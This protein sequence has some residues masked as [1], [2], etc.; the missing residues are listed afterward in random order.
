MKKTAKET[1]TDGQR[2]PTFSLSQ[3]KLP[4]IPRYLTSLGI[5]SGLVLIHLYYNPHGLRLYQIANKVNRALPT[6]FDILGHLQQKGYIRRGLHNEYYLS[7]HTK[8][9][10]SLLRDYFY[11]AFS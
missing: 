7:E 3:Q 8:Q 6:V 4:S 11:A 10:V 9:D 1:H 5:A 2:L